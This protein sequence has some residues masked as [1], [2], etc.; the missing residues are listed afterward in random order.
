MHIC[1]YVY[2]CIQIRGREREQQPGLYVLYSILTYFISPTPSS[3]DTAKCPLPHRRTIAPC[4]L[5]PP[6]FSSPHSCKL[7]ISEKRSLRPVNGGDKVPHYTSGWPKSHYVAQASLEQMAV[8]L[9]QP[10][11]YPSV[12][13]YTVEKERTNGASSSSPH[14]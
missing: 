3:R 12:A 5:S 9:P 11:K 13:D 1:A 4:A 2:A 6:S 10:P 7:Q 14:H 8:L